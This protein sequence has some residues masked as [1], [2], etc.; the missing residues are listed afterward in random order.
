MT[1]PPA[2]TSAMTGP[3][4]FVSAATACIGF[5]VPQLRAE[6][7]GAFVVAVGHVTGERLVLKFPVQVGGFQVCRRSPLADTINPS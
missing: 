5:G 3:T 6:G 2:Y 7:V 1:S 4:T